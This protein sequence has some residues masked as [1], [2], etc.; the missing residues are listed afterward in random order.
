M[1]VILK[2]MTVMDVWM[3]SWPLLIIG[4]FTLSLAG[5]VFSRRLE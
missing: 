1:G 3:N 5:W 4:A 2:D